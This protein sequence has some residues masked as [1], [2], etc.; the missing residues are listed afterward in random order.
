MIKNKD[1]LVL[2]GQWK[3]LVIFFIIIVVVAIIGKNIFD[4]LIG[5]ARLSAAMQTMKSTSTTL[6]GCQILNLAISPP[7]NSKKPT[8]LA[9]S[10]STKYAVLGTNSTSGCLYN[11]KFVTT[12]SGF[13]KGAIQAGCGCSGDG[14][15]TC[16][17]V[18]Q[19]DF[20]TN[21]K[22]TEKIN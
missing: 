6:A 1:S 18:F 11:T 17:K 22:C 15:E 16:K 5:G 21:G 10:D 7:N 20:A 14:I 2:L 12:V 8:N 19:C 9:C 3:V 13:A 4:S